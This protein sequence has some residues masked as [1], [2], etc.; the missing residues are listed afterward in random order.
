MTQEWDVIVIG[1]GPG[2]YVAAIRAS[3]LGMKT[4]L[5]E[6]DRIG[7]VCL[8][9]GCI[10]TKA[11]IHSVSL[12]RSIKSTRQYGITVSSV[13]FDL[14]AV[15]KHSRGAASRIS[16]GVEYLLKKAEVTVL[17]GRG[18]I[19][20]ENRIEVTGQDGGNST[21]TTNG[22]VIATGGRPV[23]IPGTEAIGELLMDSR[24]AM[25]PSSLPKKLIII[26]G[27]AIGV[28]FAYIYA[29]LGAKVTVV[30]M[31]D[32]VLPQSDHEIAAELA[33]AFK[34]L[35]I[36]V[37]ASTKLV[38][39]Q[40]KDDSVE[41]RLL[42]GE[43][44]IVRE[45]D[46]LLVA[47][48]VRPNSADLGFEEVGIEIDRGFIKVDDKGFT[49]IGRIYA[50]GDVVGGQLLAHKASAQGITAV[51]ALA[52]LEPDAIDLSLIPACCYCEPQ[53]AQVG[54]TE[55]ELGRR[56][57]RYIVGKFPFAA[58]AKATATGSR[59]GMVKLLF[60][61]KSGKLL[62]AHLV[63]SNVSEMIAELSLAIREGITWDGLGR[64]VHPHPSFSESV[65]EA[66]EAAHGSAI[67]I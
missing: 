51:E 30:E 67:H 54:P 34:R 65:M 64:L 60:S 9:W 61:E 14:A 52:G 41:A 16:K 4:A 8:N 59:Q 2:G 53:V 44:E 18:R 36:E 56:G 12:Y 57:E 6:K 39:V 49:G 3:Q 62:A 21:H 40:R 45:A 15:V 50:V 28:E 23:S 29:G 1:S 55:E 20:A 19:V 26:G 63:G 43:E 46:Q 13:D 42:R 66:A 32:H 31:L 35:S 48:G 5:I 24:D 58:N 11:L 38:G 10:P 37:L 33:K 47:V 17:K 22:I 7:G 25:T 27:G